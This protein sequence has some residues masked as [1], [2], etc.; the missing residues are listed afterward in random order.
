MP[1][2]FFALRIFTALF[3]FTLV[4]PAA[5]D[6]PRTASYAILSAR[7][8]AL[9][10]AIEKQVDAHPGNSGFRLVMQGEEALMLRLA[11]MEAAEHSLDIQYYSFQNDKTGKL[12]LEAL[13]EAADRGVRVRV[14][15][16]DITITKSD[17]AWG[18]LDSH[19]NI[20]MRIFNPLATA[21]QGMLGTIAGLLTR[22]QHFSRRMH[23]KVFIA[24][25]QVSIIGGRNLGDAYFDNNN[26]FNFR[27]VDILAAGPVTGEISR[28]FDSFW[29]GKEAFPIKV[30]SGVSH[31]KD[32]IS[33]MRTALKAHWRK[34]A[35]EGMF[36]NAQP[37][38]RQLQDEKPG[39]VWAKAEL[40]ADSP[41]KLEKPQEEAKSRAMS[42]LEAL[43]ADAKREVIMVT[44]YFVPGDAGVTWLKGM[45]DRGIRVRVLTN[46][47]ASTDVIAVHAGYRRYRQQLVQNG[48]DL[49][50]LKPLPGKKVK[51]GRF[52]SS[53]RAS[54]HTKLY[55]TDRKHIVVGTMNMDPRSIRLNTEIALVIHDA[56]LGER[57]V[58][59]F[60]RAARP[61]SS[62]HLGLAGDALEWSSEKND[63]PVQYDH[64]P[65]AGFWRTL[66]MR[67]YSILPFEGQL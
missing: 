6:Y 67:L 38:V 39:L 55:V 65:E 24:D 54:L 7:G 47:L 17:A 49:F 15:I 20:S 31:S 29:N 48:V 50:E 26:E 16:D 61:S 35:E 21:E 53:S 37:I 51:R 40:A 19:P 25:N 52:A 43:A 8:S 64:E 42:H 57:L 59:M 34:V 3:N 23:N 11:L 2:K 56:G 4:R 66:K 62:Y 28:S 22:L 45:V 33:R 46:S 18:M 13:M 9:K 27:D 36:R 14:L 60:E 41:C 5:S 63:T 44:P 30:L 10:S 32:S 58:S 12:L 1:K